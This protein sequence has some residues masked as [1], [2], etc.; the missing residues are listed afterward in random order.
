MNDQ[1]YNLVKYG[2]YETL[3]MAALTIAVMLQIGNELFFNLTFKT[4]QF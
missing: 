3:T 2:R 4:T 1:N